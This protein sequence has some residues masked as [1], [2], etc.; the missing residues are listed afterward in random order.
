MRQNQ[1][2][3]G[4]DKI[5]QKA[6]SQID[7]ISA[8]WWV[9]YRDYFEETE[10]S[11]AYLCRSPRPAIPMA[12]EN[13]L[14]PY[15]NSNAPLPEHLKEPLNQ[16][17]DRLDGQWTAHEQDRR[18]TIEAVE[19]RYAMLAALAEEIVVFDRLGGR[20]IE[21]QK[22]LE[23]KKRRY[24]SSATALRH[25]PPEIIAK[26]IKLAIL[27]DYGVMEKKDRLFFA[28]LRS[29]CRLWRQISLSTP[30]LWRSVG[31]DMAH[32]IADNPTAI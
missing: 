24:A 2:C 26:V 17:L 3:F 9:L 25:I 30:S 27:G 32:V 20:I 16:F 28:H 6:D 13:H 7:N 4:G 12:F 10:V 18:R 1:S 29:V 22:A 8:Y 11:L 15:V 14:H 21:A 31:V 19:S 23:A 5:A